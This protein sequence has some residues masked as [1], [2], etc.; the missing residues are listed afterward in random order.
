MKYALIVGDGMADLPVDALGGKTPLEAAN[1][2]NL[3]RLAREGRTGLVRFCPPGMTPGTEVCMMAVMSY[4][5]REHFRGRGPVEAL[6]RGIALKKS[7]VAFRCNLVTIEGDRLVDFSA[8]HI[9][10]AE[11]SALVQMLDKRLGGDEIAFH[12]G[13]GYRHLMVWRSGSADVKTVAPHDI[14]GQ[15]WKGHLPKGRGETRLAQLMEDSRVLLEFHEVNVARKRKGLN[16]AN[17]IWLWSPGKPP[18]V[19]TFRDKYGIGSGSVITAVDVVRGYGVLAGLEILEVKGATGYFDTDYKAKGQAA[20][21]ALGKQEF[22]LV[23]VEAPDEAGHLGSHEEKVKAIE[24]IDAAIVGPMLAAQ[25]KLGDLSILV[26]PD[27]PTPVTTRAHS[28]GPVPVVL[29]R[30]NEPAAGPS[31]YTEAS[32]A[33]GPLSTD[34]G[35]TLL[36][37]LFRP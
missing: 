8:G 21:K 36:D 13:V 10:S 32:A 9:T 24:A 31:R 27:H 23:H 22:V 20:V 29:W 18:A 30:S 25:P 1:T 12:A 3:D 28:D 5:P 7:E 16:P 33:E 15:P 11:A 4:D 14:V 37:R 19:P 2:P 26:L 34:E 6:G 17:M 35:W